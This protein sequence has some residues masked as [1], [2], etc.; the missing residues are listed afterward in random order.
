[1][2][3]W[4]THSQFIIAHINA[5][6]TLARDHCMLANALAADYLASCEVAQ[7]SCQQRWS[8]TARVLKSGYFNTNGQQDQAATLMECHLRRILLHIGVM[9]TIRRWRGRS[10]SSTV[11]GSCTGCA[12]CTAKLVPWFKRGNRP[13][14]P[15]GHRPADSDDVCHSVR[16]RRHMRHGFSNHVKPSSISAN[17][18]SS[19]SEKEITSWLTLRIMRLSR[20]AACRKFLT[21]P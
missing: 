11:F 19:D 16:L 3:L 6:M 5:M 13:R 8:T 18:T 12:R 4:S 17:T 15:D 2:R 7:Q 21:R 14:P 20:T 9:H 1:M 10:G